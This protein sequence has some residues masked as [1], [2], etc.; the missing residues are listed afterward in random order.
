M[1]LSLYVITD[2]KIGLGRSHIFLAEE[3]LKGG[4]TVIQLRDK[5]KTGRELYKIGVKLREITKKYGALFIVNDRVDVA[6]AV[7]ADGVHL[8]MNDLPISVAR[9]IAG[10]KFIIG[11]SVSSP[12]EAVLA[13]KEG[14]DYISAQSIFE[15]SSKEDVR[16]I[17]IEGLKAIVKVSSLPVIAIGGIN[18][19][20][21][22]EVI[23][24]G[25]RGIAVISAVVSKEDVK[26]ATEEL[27]KVIAR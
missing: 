7:G 9:K 6:L 26:S 19:H 3:A 21:A 25:A 16:V 8:G 1:D 18:K 4:A 2:E 27:K 20:N 24:A 11:A 5:E 12:E 23:N 15:T 14:A 13:E 22:R 10:N 17:G